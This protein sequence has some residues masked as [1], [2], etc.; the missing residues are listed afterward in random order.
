MLV[1]YSYAPDSSDRFAWLSAVR[2]SRV[3][4]RVH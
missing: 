1:Y 4:E 3:G 2:W